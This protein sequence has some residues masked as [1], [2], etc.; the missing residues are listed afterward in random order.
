MTTYKVGD[1]K[2]TITVNRIPLTVAGCNDACLCPTNG[3]FIH[4]NREI[5]CS[6]HVISSR[7]TDLSVMQLDPASP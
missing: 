3:E 1:F 4:I 6:M 7:L 5:T 2:D